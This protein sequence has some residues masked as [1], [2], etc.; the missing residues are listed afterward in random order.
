MD[1][2]QEKIRKKTVQAIAD[3]DLL[4]P[5]DKVMVCLSGGK[6]STALAIILSEIKSRA[7]F[8][9]DLEFIML[10]QNQPGFDATKYQEWLLTKGIHLTIIGEDT[11][12]IVIEKTKPGKSF[13]GLCSRLRRGIL[14]TYAENNG[15]TKIALGHHRDDLNETLLLNLF[16]AGKLSSM[17][18]KLFADDGKNIVIRPFAYVPEKWLQAYVAQLDAP[19]MP[20]NLCGSQEKLR[21]KKMKNLLTQLEQEDPGIMAS[22]LNAQQNIKSSQFLSSTGSKQS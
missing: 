12:S 18:A 2:L 20:C 10:D 7:P 11:Y 9:F 15:F 1:Q 19:I 13:C 21:R 5:S 6:D 3:H 17:P 14:Y 8:K 22:M 4:T 16:Y